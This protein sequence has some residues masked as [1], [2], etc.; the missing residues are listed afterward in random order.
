M[1]TVFWDE[2]EVIFPDFLEPGQTTDGDYVEKQHFE[3]EDLLYELL[4][5]CSLHPLW[6]PWK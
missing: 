1:S 4:L 3:A 6:F 2:K 5:L